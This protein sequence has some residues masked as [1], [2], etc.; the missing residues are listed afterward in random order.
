MPVVSSQ[1]IR[2]WLG[3][4][5]EAVGALVYPWDCI[6]CGGDAEDTPFC[7]VCRAQLV[8]PQ[9]H[10]CPRCAMPV[11]PWANVVD[12]CSECRGR[13][14][15]FDRAIALGSYEGPVRELCLLLKHEPYAWLA[16]WLVAVLVSARPELHNESRDALV[17]PIP[18]HW[19][20]HWERGYNQADALARGLAQAL[21]VPFRQLLRRPVSTPPLA[22]L[23]RTE[24]T[25]L[26]RGAFQAR[27]GSLVQGRTVL[28]VDDI[29]TSGAT[30]GAAA[31]A[32]KQAGAVR[33]VVVVI[34]RA[35]GKP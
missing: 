2:R 11:G 35:E 10:V 21:S 14:L 17:A 27:A 24:R 7:N 6:L 9:H 1:T 15:G 20:R 29:L 25:R 19:R 34:A 22:L 5:G 33:V 13:S 28:L 16:P 31:R 3:L 4:A 30:S 12:G 8:A 32:L 18:L 23:G 26:L